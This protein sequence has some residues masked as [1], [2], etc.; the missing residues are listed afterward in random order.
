MI[1]WLG[2]I[3]DSTRRT[4]TVSDSKLDKLKVFIR[5][6]LAQPAVSARHLAQVAGKIISM[7]PAV[8]PAAQYTRAFF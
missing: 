8:A 2:F 7:S 5:E 1:K 6:L 3:L 4:F